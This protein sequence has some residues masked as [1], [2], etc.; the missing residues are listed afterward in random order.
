MRECIVIVGGGLMGSGIAAVSALA[1]NATVI[2]DVDQQKAQKGVLDA[3]KCVKELRANGLTSEAKANRAETL[4]ESELTMEDA[5]KK[6]KLVI[7]AVSENLELKQKLFSQIDE[8]L[9]PE[10]PITSNTSGLRISDIARYTKHPERTVST[11]FWFPG[12][13][14]PLVEV[15]AGDHTDIEVARRVRDMLREWGKAPVLVKKDMPGQLANRIYQAIIREAIQIVSM[16]LADA[17][18]VD[19]AIKMGMGIRFPIMGPL[20]HMDTI[21]LELTA[22]VQNTVLPVISDAK[23]A[24]PYLAELI[25]SGRCGYKDGQGFYDWY[26]KDMDDITEKRNQYLM[27]AIQLLKS[28][29]ETK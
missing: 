25:Q 22:S 16:G 3:L 1:G 26:G 4:I 14:I 23:E 29:G 9:P 10:V 8:L 11:H 27:K 13:L 2:V 17:E 15:V 12:H 28:C 24:N 7:E 19:T 6:A 21:G 20:E 5:L 18:D